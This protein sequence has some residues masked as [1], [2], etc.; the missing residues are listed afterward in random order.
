MRGVGARW[1]KCP[2][3]EGRRAIRRFSLWFSKV[4]LSLHPTGQHRG[5]ATRSLPGPARIRYSACGF[6]L[7]VVPLPANKCQGSLLPYASWSPHL[8]LAGNR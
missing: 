3:R 8:R 5:S 6:L 1:L 7:E 2:P 4:S